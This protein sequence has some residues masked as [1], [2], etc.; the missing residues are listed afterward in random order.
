VVNIVRYTELQV[1]ST[2]DVTVSSKVN[3]SMACSSLYLLRCFSCI[4]AADSHV[5]LA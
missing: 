1:G 4:K 5:R 3:Q 2:I